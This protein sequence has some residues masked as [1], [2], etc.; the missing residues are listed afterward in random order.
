MSESEEEEII[1]SHE[2][3]SYDSAP[4]PADKVGPDKLLRPIEVAD[5]MHH[6]TT[7]KSREN[8]SALLNAIENDESTTT[9]ERDDLEIAELEPK[10]EFDLKSLSKFSIGKNW[11]SSH[12]R[13]QLKRFSTN[14]SI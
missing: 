2:L 9:D 6:M 1:V 14:S 11:Q 5:K 7:N 10:A 8:T 12:G 4:K 3:R 13:C